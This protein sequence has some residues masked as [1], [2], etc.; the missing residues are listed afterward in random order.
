MAFK[1]PVREKEY[2]KAYQ[3]NYKKKKLIQLKDEL[4]SLA[5]QHE[6]ENYI[7]DFI[8][9]YNDIDE[10]TCKD[11]EISWYRFLLQCIKYQLV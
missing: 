8:I 2:Q 5:Q 4:K 7:N 3:Q 11:S 10:F 1:D 6:I 9:I